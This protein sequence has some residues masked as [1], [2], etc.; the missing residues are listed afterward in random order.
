MTCILTIICSFLC[1]LSQNNTIFFSISLSLSFKKKKILNTLCVRF[2]RIRKNVC[3]LP[4]IKMRDIC[5]CAQNA[6]Q[7]LKIYL[8]KPKIYQTKYRQK[9]PTKY[10]KFIYLNIY[11][12]M[13][14]ELPTIWNRHIYDTNIYPLY[15]YI[16]LYTY[17]HVY[18]RNA[19]DF[20][21][22]SMRIF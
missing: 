18:V 1:I 7:Q 10:I 15:I 3:Y 13:S 20:M 6:T 9:I 4:L 17:T 16:Y 21:M 22:K 2:T 5:E 12:Y 19:T 8:Y 14:C 11:T